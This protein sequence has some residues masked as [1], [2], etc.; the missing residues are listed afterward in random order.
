M[1]EENELIMDTSDQAGVRELLTGSGYADTAI[2]YFL[3]KAYMGS[4]PNANQV[5]E[6]TGHCG[7]TMKI[8]LKIEQD[9][10]EDARIQ[11]LGCPGAVASAMAAMEMIKGLP[12]TEAYKLKD[13][14]IF[15]KLGFLPDQKQ[16]CIRLTVKTL[17]KAL[18]EYQAGRN[19]S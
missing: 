4:L 19:G 5:S 12:V 10:I 3:N 11:V 13:A 9:R 14:E 17:Q 16:H 7:D 18:E 8:F 1:S 6:L 2:D 15:K